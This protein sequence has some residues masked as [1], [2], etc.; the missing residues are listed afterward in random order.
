M[1][2]PTL[3]A[4]WL[5]Q[6]ALVVA[7]I[8]AAKAD[9]EQ[10]LAGLA[11]DMATVALDISHSEEIDGAGVQLLLALQVELAERGVAL[12]LMGLQAAVLACFSRYRLDAC[13]AC[14]E[15]L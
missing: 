2:A 3:E 9:C 12:R 10:Q 4:V 5:L 11:G 14:C 13:L 15:A 1:S 6:P 8:S 7:S